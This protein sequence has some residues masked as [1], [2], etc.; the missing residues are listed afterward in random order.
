VLLPGNEGAQCQV[1]GAVEHG[2]ANLKPAGGCRWPKR[3]AARLPGQLPGPSPQPGSFGLMIRGPLCRSAPGCWSPGRQSPRA[4]PFC[5]RRSSRRTEGVGAFAGAAHGP[6]HTKRSILG[7]R[8]AATACCWT[9]S[10]EQVPAFIKEHVFLIKKPTPTQEECEGGRLRRF[11][12]DHPQ[13][14]DPAGLLCDDRAC[15]A[16]DTQDPPVLPR[17]GGRGMYTKHVRRELCAGYRHPRL[18]AR[19]CWHARPA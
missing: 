17:H 6:L 19:R 5:L 3:N 12:T 8:Q 14:L 11:E 18:R 9:S 2:P 13:V 16:R 1:Q 4:R 10:A 7:T 15:A